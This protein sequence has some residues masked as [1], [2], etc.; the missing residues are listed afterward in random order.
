MYKKPIWR[1]AAPNTKL[2]LI[3]LKRLTDCYYILMSADA[4][5]PNYF[6][7][8]ENPKR[9]S[10]VITN[11]SKKSTNICLWIDDQNER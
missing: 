1:L 4:L 2:L 11:S 7:G 3:S 8:P 5:Y 10:I 9:N 6:Y